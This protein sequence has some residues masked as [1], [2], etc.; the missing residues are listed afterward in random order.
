MP[1]SVSAYNDWYARGMYQE[2]SAVFKHHKETWGDQKDFGYKD[3]I[4]MFK[5]ENWD[6]VEWAQFFKSVG[7]RYV[8]PS[9]EH[10]DHF[11][12]W[13]SELTDWNAAKMGPKRDVIGELAEAVRAEGMYYGVSNHRARGWNFYTYDE[14]FDTMN[15]DY[16]DFYWPQLD[17]EPDQAWLEDW[18]ARLEEVVD[19]YHPD[20]MWFDYGWKDAA[21]ESYKKNYA[22]YYYNH[23]AARNQEV[24]LI[25]KGDHLPLGAGLLDVERGK[26]DRLWPDLWMTDT[27]VFEDTWGYVEGAPMKTVE[28]LLH[29]FIDIVSKNGVLLLNVGPKADGTIPDDQR[30]VLIEMGKWLAINGESIYNTRPFNVD[31]EGE[32]IRYTR[33]GNAVYAIFLEQP[34]GTV[35]LDNLSTQKLGGLEVASVTLLDGGKSLE[36]TRTDTGL[37]ISFP[38]ELPGSRAWVAKISLSGIGF[39][40]PK[41]TIVNGIDGGQVSAFG[42]VY[43]FTD[44]PQSIR[45]NFY[46]NRDRMGPASQVDLAP[47]ETGDVR[48]THRLTNHYGAMDMI[49]PSVDEGVYEFTFGQERPGESPAA[50]RAF[51]AVPLKGT[52]LFSDHDEDIFADADF[53]DSSWKT[54]RV[55][56]AWPIGRKAETVGWYRKH[57]TISQSWEGRELFLNLGVIADAD[58]VYVNGH[59]VGEKGVEMV[60]FHFAHEIRKF[61]IPAEYINFGG[62]NTI[63][64][65]VFNQQHDGG[66]VGPPGFI[67]IAE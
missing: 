33:H 39:S 20:V 38:S 53:D 22:A 25:Y 58:T 32:H 59:K 67:T 49:L 66:L 4:P 7:A 48:F 26:L 47:G 31:H 56:G 57:V 24:V 19:K 29:D 28:T 51:P 8:V 27:T 42:A 50:I 45:T 15:P 10:H 16:A 18:Q 54:A 3:F 2:G 62:E 1:N 44:E 9:A 14:A 35:S 41:V 46:A 6:P 64:V 37:E 52:L 55:P 17:K 30:E 12:M 60:E 65:R 21:F 5:A 23:A 40:K 13:D 63:A 11:A 36:H 34:N 61:N 43:N